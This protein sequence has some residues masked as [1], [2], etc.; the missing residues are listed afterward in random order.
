M[1]GAA[2]EKACLDQ[3]EQ[4][5]IDTRLQRNSHS[6]PKIRRFLPQELAKP[7]C[8][9]DVAACADKPEVA[10]EN[11]LVSLALINRDN[12]RERCYLND[13]AKQVKLAPSLIGRLERKVC[14]SAADTGG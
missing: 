11:Y 2:N 3:S 1:I 14:S 7:L 4:A 8:P 10:I 6:P 13:L 5:R 12:E 9:A